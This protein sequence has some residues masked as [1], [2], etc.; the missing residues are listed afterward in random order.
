MIKSIISDKDFIVEFDAS[1]ESGKLNDADFTW[2]V[3]STGSN[4]ANVIYKGKSFNIILESREGDLFCLK[5]NGKK[6]EVSTKDKMALLLESMGLNIVTEQKI[7]LVKAPMPGLVLRTLVNP[8]DAVKKG[9][10]LLVL[11]AMKMENMIK[12]PSDAVVSKVSV[13]LGQAVEKN[14]I[15][16]EFD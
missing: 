13:K 10:A 1:N 11:E 4:S 2:D 15:L 8:G 5:I 3:L 16:I 14:Q 6:V 7:N 9:D 12:S